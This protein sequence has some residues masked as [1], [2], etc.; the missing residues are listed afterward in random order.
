MFCAKTRGVKDILKSL[1]SRLVSGK[2]HEDKV[3]WKKEEL[4]SD[5][6][7]FWFENFFFFFF[8]FLKSAQTFVVFS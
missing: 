3:R 5:F 4:K 6:Q 8:F 7:T 1:G 2:Y